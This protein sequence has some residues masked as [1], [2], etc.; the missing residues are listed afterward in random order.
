MSP[1]PKNIQSIAHSFSM[2]LN[3]LH[4]KCANLQSILVHATT[5]LRSPEDKNFAL[6]HSAGLQSLDEVT[7]ILLELANLSLSLSLKDRAIFDNPEILSHEIRQNLC[8]QSL[9]DRILYGRECDSE[10][11]NE[12][13]EIFLPPN[14]RKV[15]Q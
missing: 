6:E 14:P 10:F 5:T 1:A 15:N 7:Q 3:A 2:E 4:H 11:S 12:A 9:R 13:E 8:L